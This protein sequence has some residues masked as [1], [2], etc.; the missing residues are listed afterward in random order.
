MLKYVFLGLFIA[1]MILVGIISRKKV[2]NVQDFFLGGRKMGPWLSAFAYGTTYFSAVI[3]IGYA[4]KTG[5]GF[6]IS[7]TFIG[8]GNALL[9]SLLAWLVLAKRTRRM[10]HE[11]GAATMP[12]FFEKRYNS[13]AMKIATALIIFVFLV[14]Y[15]ASVYQG[16]AYLFETT[17]GVPFIYCMAA[18]ALLTGIYLL[19]G[20]YVATALNDFIQGIIMLIGVAFMILFILSN[21]AVGGLSG[22]LQK[23]GL[24]RTACQP[25]SAQPMNC[26][27]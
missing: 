4:G 27:V 13:K 22:G 17:F 10:T 19:L 14:P 3:F 15:S 7:A 16:L 21:P 5:W 8:I 1:V 20:G 12:E 6:G 25:F 11:L 2:Q 9:G 24:G 23:L 18:M 26:W